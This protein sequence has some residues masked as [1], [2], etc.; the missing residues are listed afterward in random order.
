[1]GT[2]HGIPCLL[3]F[4]AI[5][6]LFCPGSSSSDHGNPRLPNAVVVG[7]VYCDTCFQQEFSRTSHFI[8]ALLRG[9]VL[10]HVFFFFPAAQV[11]EVGSPR[12]LRRV[13]HLS[14]PAAA[15]ALL[16]GAQPRRLPPARRHPDLRR[17][18]PAAFSPSLP[19]LPTIPQLP[20]LP[21]LPTIPQLPTLP[22]LPGLDCRNCRDHRPPAAPPRS[23]T[24]SRTARSS[25]SRLRPAPITLRPSSPHHPLP[26]S[27]VDSPH[28]P[29]QVSAA[30]SPHHPLRSYAVGSP[31][32]PFQSPPSVLPTNPF[33]SP[34]SILPTNPFGSP[35]SLVPSNPFQSPPS[36]LP[37]NPFQS[38]PPAFQLP[39]FP[40]PQS[41][42]F[43]GT[44]PSFPS[45]KGG[46]AATP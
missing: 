4:L 17:L 42:F 5:G 12:L 31:T 43:P 32:N 21:Q 25:S 44:P 6:L 39:Q 28:H 36:V 46:A 40:F 19:Q 3:L 35:P 15:G 8:P 37:S 7:T 30:D 14:S 33:Q 38:P 27:A 29:L 11:D 20:T 13:L 34:P 9:G 45:S 16:P 18:S 2:G 10:R 41:P 22:S 24:R 1:M 26:S 23:W